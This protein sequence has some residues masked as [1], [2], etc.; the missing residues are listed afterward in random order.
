MQNEIVNLIFPKPRGGQMPLLAPPADA[1]A[2]D[3]PL[4]ATRLVFCLSK[5]LVSTAVKFDSFTCTLIST[6]PSFLS[7]VLRDEGHFDSL[8][9]PKH[10]TLNDLRYFVPAIFWEYY[11]PA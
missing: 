1:H 11:A 6:S 3:N 9:S 4:P 5:M 10:R 7:R 8:L 2:N